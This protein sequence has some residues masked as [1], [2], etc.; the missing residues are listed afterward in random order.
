M[1]MQK[2]HLVLLGI[3]IGCLFSGLVLI[4]ALVKPESSI[5][6]SPTFTLSPITV[7]ISGEILKP[8]VY[9]MPA[10]SHV[11]DLI[12]IAGGFTN[13]SM[14][15]QLNLARY[16]VD[17]ELIE[18]KSS[19]IEKQ[20]LVNINTASKTELL[21]LPGIGPVLAEK[22]IAYRNLHKGFLN[23]SE[24]QKVP[25]IGPEVYSKIEAFII[26]ITK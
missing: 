9:E 21:E 25:G 6:L 24:I 11:E 22:I 10:G 26:T 12:E 20:P 19:Q 16:L 18:I 15:N 1:N 7:Q 3:A 23:I 4:F 17:G 2:W 5:I 8:G 14:K 13:G